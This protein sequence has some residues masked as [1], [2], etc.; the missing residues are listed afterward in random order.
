MRKF[1]DAFPREQISLLFQPVMHLASSRITGV[2]ALVR[3]DHP[4]LGRLGATALLAAADDAGMAIQLGNYIRSG[5]MLE[6]MAWPSAL[7]TLTL[8]LNATAADL[9]HPGFL[10]EL[11]SAIVQSGFPSHRLILE[12]TEDKPIME[13]RI[14]ELVLEQLHLLGILVFIDDFGT[15]YSS[16]AWLA[17]LPISGIKF[18][19][20][21]T[22]MMRGNKREKL[23]IDAVAT[24]ARML[25]LKIVAEGVEDPAD[26]VAA[27]ST[28]CD[29][30]QG[31]G[32]A[33]PIPS[34]ELAKFVE[35][36]T[37]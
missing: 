11:M 35:G 13:M 1:H 24:L 27:Y 29:A 3:W 18:D 15:G 34:E 10:D 28:A 37:T 2:E 33:F 23:V 20:S 14:I 30:V 12:I 26:V 6:A 9:A 8:S 32:I 17:Q 4:T 5:A 19:R 36:W 22:S 31:F 16:L 7:A 21:F 25:D